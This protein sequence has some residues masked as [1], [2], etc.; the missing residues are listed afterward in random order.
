MKTIKP[1]IV[2]LCGSTRFH[3]TFQEANFKETLN[4][5]IVLSI[6]CDTKA[7]SDLFS[8]WGKAEMEAIKAKLDELHLRKIDLAHEVLILNVDGYVGKST[9]KEW[10]YA[11]EQGKKIRFWL[12]WRDFRLKA[13]ADIWSIKAGELA[14]PALYCDGSVNF[15]FPDGVGVCVN[16]GVDYE[17][18]EMVKL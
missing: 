1:R 17:L 10:N 11:I 14:E 6:G 3:K 7:D 13:K 9:A 18:F 2:C 8:G 16:Q 12:D 5:K 15:W 4:G